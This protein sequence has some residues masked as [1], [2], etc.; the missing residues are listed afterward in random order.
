LV[1]FLWA[2]DGLEDEFGFDCGW[3]VTKIAD[4]NTR[5]WAD[6]SAPFDSDLLAFG[7]DGTGD[8]FAIRLASDSTS[9]VYH[10]T[11]IELTARRIAP[12]LPT[13]YEGWLSGTIKV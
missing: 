5:A 3:S 11:W 2:S 1:E 8:W 12:D 7:D 4:E 6:D 13:F 9:G 10:W